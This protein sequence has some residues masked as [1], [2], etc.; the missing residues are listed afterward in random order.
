MHC[1]AHNKVC[2][3]VGRRVDVFSACWV[4]AEGQKTPSAPFR[5]YDNLVR[6]PMNEAY[7]DMPPR[8]Q[9]LLMRLKLR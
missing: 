9:S 2:Q 3:T 4:V 6:N 1:F 7:Q 8:N 5:T